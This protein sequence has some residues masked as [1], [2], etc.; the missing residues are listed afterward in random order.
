MEITGV[1]KFQIIQLF[2]GN[3]PAGHKRQLSAALK[4]KRAP[5]AA[6]ALAAEMREV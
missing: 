5:A 1:G 2:A 6:V 3:S 4:K